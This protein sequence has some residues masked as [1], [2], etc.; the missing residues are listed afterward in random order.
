MKKEKTKQDK[1]TEIVHLVNAAGAS[2]MTVNGIEL[3]GNRIVIDGSVF[4][5]I[6]I[7]TYLSRKDTLRMVGMI[8]K[9]PAIIG[10][11]LSLPFRRKK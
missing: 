3:D 2:M 5:A 11:V 6:P 1:K 9:K 8:F 4:G 7:K 10:Y